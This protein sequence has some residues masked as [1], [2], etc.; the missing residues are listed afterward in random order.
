[1]GILT[2]LHSAAGVVGSIHDLACQALRHG[3]LAASTGVSG[4]P[5][6]T[7]GLT[8][9]RTHLHGDLIGGAAHTAGLDLQGG[10]DVLQSL[11]VNLHGLLTGLVL[12]DIE[13]AIDHLLGHALLTVQH[14][15]VGQLS[16][17]NRVIQR[18]GQ[19]LPLGYI[20]SSGHFASLL[21]IKLE[22]IGTQTALQFV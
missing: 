20:S 14:N 22:I 15:A 11:G 3:A 5:A 7:Q 17:Q 6:Q 19:N 16:H 8:T 2:L 12:D 1:M 13:G 18:I 4:Q 9:G 10:H 21:L